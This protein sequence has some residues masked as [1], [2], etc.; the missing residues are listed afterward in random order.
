MPERVLALALHRARAGRADELL[1]GKLVQR[2]LELALVAAADLGQGTDPEHLPEHG[3]VLE[4]ALPLRRKRVQAGGDQRLQALRQIRLRQ[5][6]SLRLQAAIGEQ[7]H[8]LL[9]VERIAARPLE[10]CP[11]ELFAEDG[12]GDQM[13]DEL[14]RLL[15]PRAAAG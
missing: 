6:L 14:G 2:Q 9:R 11:L 12:L 5:G 3:R 4:Q 13:R 10:H 15:D 1:A 7:P 8:E